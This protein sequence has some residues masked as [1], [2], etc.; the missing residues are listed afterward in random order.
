MA[1]YIHFTVNGV[2]RCRHH[3]GMCE[4]SSDNGFAVWDEFQDLTKQFPKHKIAIVWGRCPEM[5]AISKG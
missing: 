3:D 5:E 2:P 1:D 4:M